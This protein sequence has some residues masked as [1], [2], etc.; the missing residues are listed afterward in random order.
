MSLAKPLCEIITW[1]DLFH[2][3]G[4]P[5]LEMKIGF[6]V[7]QLNALYTCLQCETLLIVLLVSTYIPVN[8]DKCHC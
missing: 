2:E 8:V 3:T 1:I 5:E 7:C 4:F 6:L